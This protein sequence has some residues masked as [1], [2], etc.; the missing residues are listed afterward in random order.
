MS[1]GVDPVAVLLG[2]VLILFGLCLI[3][4]GGACTFFLLGSLDSTSGTGGFLVI[5]VATLAFGVLCVWGG[6]RAMRPPR[7]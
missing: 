7:G 5:S 4:A 3:F 2:V 1:Q 6:I